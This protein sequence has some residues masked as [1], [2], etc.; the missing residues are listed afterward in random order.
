MVM[1]TTK[2]VLEFAH[3]IREDMVLHLSYGAR[4]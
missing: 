3:K 4:P 2:L 1:H